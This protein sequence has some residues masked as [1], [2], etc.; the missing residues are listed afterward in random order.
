MNKLS[1]EYWTKVRDGEIDSFYYKYE[2]WLEKQVNDLRTQLDDINARIRWIP[3][4]E[5]PPPD[6][7]WVQVTDGDGEVYTDFQENGEW[8]YNSE[9]RHTHWTKYLDP[10]KPESK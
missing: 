5:S 9:N 1:Q 3:V 6:G 7:L 4:T 8:C 2:T 10:P